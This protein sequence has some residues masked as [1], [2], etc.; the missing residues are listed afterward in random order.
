MDP[1]ALQALQAI[2]Q[3]LTPEQRA[4]IHTQGSALLG[5]LAGAAPLLAGSQAGGAAWAGA[6]SP[7][8]LPAPSPQQPA[9]PAPSAQP[10][11]GT[12]LGAASRADALTDDALNDVYGNPNL[13]NAHMMRA[14]LDEFKGARLSFLSAPNAHAPDPSP[15]A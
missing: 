5:A 13:P 8:R 3:S 10:S 4:L 9:R 15:P 12:T 7:Q 6:P 1:A 14:I 2:V 11:G